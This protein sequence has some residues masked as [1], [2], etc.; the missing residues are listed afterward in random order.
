MQCMTRLIAHPPEPGQYNVVNQ[1]SGFYSINQVAHTVAR[2]ASKEFNL[3]V[4]IQRVG[5]PRG[6]GG[7]G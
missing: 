3:P 4:I 5:N 7:P 2:I 1:M 6:Y